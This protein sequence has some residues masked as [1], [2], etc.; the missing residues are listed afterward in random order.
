LFGPMAWTVLLGMETAMHIY[1]SILLGWY[2]STP[3]KQRESR[4]QMLLALCTAFAISTRYEAWFIIGAAG[5]VLLFERK[6]SRLFVLAGTA[7][8]TTL[9]WGYFFWQ[10]S[11]FIVPTTLTVKS[12]LPELTVS[13]VLTLIRFGLSQVY[14]MPYILVF[15][16]LLLYALWK[17]AA[18]SKISQSPVAKILTITLLALLAHG[19]GGA[20]Y[21]YGRYECYL[22]GTGVLGLGMSFINMELGRA[23]KAQSLASKATFVAM[24][25]GLMFPFVLRTGYYLFQAPLSSHNVYEQPWQVAQF[26]KQQ[27]DKAPLKIA[28]ND[29]GAVTYYNDVYLTDLVGISDTEIARLIAEKQYHPEKVWS[30]VE[31]RGVEIAVIHDFWTGHLLPDH[32]VKV[33]D[34]TIENNVNLAGETIS[35]FAKDSVLAAD[36]RRRIEAF[37]KAKK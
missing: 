24:I 9:A 8:A 4:H 33:D 34:W 3:A 13:G 11:G 10:G 35:F 16:I 17:E 12:S 6:W 20:H 30:I 18:H 22:L 7:L 21:G 36:W 1:S 31:K 37:K 32:W 5:L 28:L 14:D 2:V 23:W 15:I 19:F 29:V 27:S 25:M 26:L